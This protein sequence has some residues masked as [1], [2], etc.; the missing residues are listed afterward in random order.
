ME[1]LQLLRLNPPGGEKIA[2]DADVR[3]KLLDLMAETML[4]IIS[5]EREAGHERQSF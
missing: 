4:T 2:L 5:L 1:Q 3:E